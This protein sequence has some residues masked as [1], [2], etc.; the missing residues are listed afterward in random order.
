MS[1]TSSFMFGRSALFALVIGVVVMSM[2]WGGR[3][4]GSKGSWW[5]G[6]IVLLI[7][8]SLFFG[9]SRVKFGS[10]TERRYASRPA[11]ADIKEEIDE[12]MGEAKETAKNALRDAKNAMESAMN[13]SNKDKKS[14]GQVRRSVTVNRPPEAPQMPSVPLTW[15]IHIDGNDRSVD[16]KIV[17]NRIYEEAAERLRVWLSEQIPGGRYIQPIYADELKK[18][19]VLREEDVSLFPESL[20]N[21]DGTTTELF[22]GTAKLI[23]TPQLQAKFIEDG[24]AYAKDRL[25]DEKLEQQ[26]G[27]S[28]AIIV[29]TIC[30]MLLGSYRSY[31][32]WMRN[33]FAVAALG[34]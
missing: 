25:A 8:L 5:G 16:K 30:A 32:A 2:F 27:T 15:T 24:L 6:L 18:K 22:G 26:A 20:P 7:L 3:S 29:A 10:T 13:Q 21:T 19:G 1:E 28:V 14:T 12:A 9:F 33:K 34:Q 31:R 17:V 11:F 4:K 23:L